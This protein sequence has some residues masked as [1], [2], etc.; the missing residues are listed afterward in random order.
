MVDLPD[1][2]SWMADLSG[3]QAFA[4]INRLRPE[5]L[6]IFA[7]SDAPETNLRHIWSSLLPTIR[8]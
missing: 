7:A 6:V 1:L 2:D 5:V 8:Q 3:S 4:R